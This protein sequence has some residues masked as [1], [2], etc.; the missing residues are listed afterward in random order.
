[1]ARI[2]AGPVTDLAAADSEGEISA[3]ARAASTPGQEVTSSVIRW[4]AVGVSV[5]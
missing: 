1:M 3:A 4:L 5:M 2:V